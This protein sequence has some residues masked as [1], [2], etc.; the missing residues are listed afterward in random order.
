M[1]S[2]R[3]AATRAQMQAPLFSRD[4]LASSN[5]GSRVPA[6]DRD[7]G[8]QSN[9]PFV[10][11][12]SFHV[13]STLDLSPRPRD[14]GDEYDHDHHRR[15]HRRNSRDLHDD[16]RI[17]DAF[18]NDVELDLHAEAG[19]RGL[20]DGGHRRVDTTHHPHHQQQHQQ[21][22]QDMQ[23][24]RSERPGSKNRRSD[25][26]SREA[27]SRPAQLIATVSNSST[28]SGMPRST[29]AAG[30]HHTS[31]AQRSTS[32]F[33]SS[34]QSDSELSDADHVHIKAGAAELKSPDLTRQQ[35]Q[36]QQP[37]M[38]GSTGTPVHFA[39]AAPLPPMAGHSGDQIS[40]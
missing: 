2:T 3:G 5:T 32:P 24:S 19:M 35:Q 1:I 7:S 29:G 13:L 20:E 4:G 18:G 27:G 31:S 37:R 34:S 38:A 21:H 12:S 22:S 36:R 28:S 25:R 14:D 10:R 6:N 9:A 40:P 8:G 30:D 11:S 33:S 16:D 39:R 17:D 23:R 26:A 15:R